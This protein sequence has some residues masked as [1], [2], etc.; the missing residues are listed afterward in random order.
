M[1]DFTK[2]IYTYWRKNRKTNH[3]VWSGEKHKTLCSLKVIQNNRT[4]PIINHD[5]MCK[6][7]MKTYNNVIEKHSK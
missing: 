3:I 6:K 2:M 1:G 5:N 7:C 4:S